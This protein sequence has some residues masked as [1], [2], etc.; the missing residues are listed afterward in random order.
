MLFWGPSVASQ[1]STTFTSFAADAGG[2]D[3]R[4]PFLVVGAD[5]GGE[6]LG[7]AADRGGAEREQARLH[8][9]GVDRVDAI[10]GEL[11]LEFARQAAWGEQAPPHPGIESRNAG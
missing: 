5:E 3:D 11:R 2:L 7:R 1:S 8:G 4:S 10:L 9:R 6:H